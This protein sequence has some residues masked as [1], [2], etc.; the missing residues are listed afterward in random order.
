VKGRRGLAARSLHSLDV[1]DEESCP[2][3][4][5]AAGKAPTGKKKKGY[6][7]EL[8]SRLDK[9]VDK[10]KEVV[11]PGLLQGLIEIQEM[12]DRGPKGSGLA[13]VAP[14][15]PDQAAQDS[16]AKSDQGQAA[17]DLQRQSVQSGLDMMN[18]IC[19]QGH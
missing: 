13:A 9:E 7:R 16:A 5:V 1:R 18:L 10:L 11:A 4:S 12:L 15:Q 3:R 6:L 19:S 14:K 17:S 8:R 2:R